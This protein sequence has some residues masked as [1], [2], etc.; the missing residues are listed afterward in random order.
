MFNLKL[1]SCVD[2]KGFFNYELQAMHIYVMGEG[3]VL[4]A[5]FYHLQTYV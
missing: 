3:V 2:K 1:I 5:P 4:L